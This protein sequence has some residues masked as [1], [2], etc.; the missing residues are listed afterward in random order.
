MLRTTLE[1]EARR[2]RNPGPQ[3]GR[4]LGSN[5]GAELGPKFRPLSPTVLLPDACSSRSVL[6]LCTPSFGGG[7]GGCLMSALLLVPG[8]CGRAPGA[9]SPHLLFSKAPVPVLGEGK[10]VSSCLLQPPQP[11]MPVTLPRAASAPSYS[12]RLPL[13]SR[14]SHSSHCL[15]PP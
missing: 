14:R 8:P 15:P 11:R 7:A 1:G 13:R 2:L 4:G 5:S 9:T 6:A 3:V 10:Q 12:A